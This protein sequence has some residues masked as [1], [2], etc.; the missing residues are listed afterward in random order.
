MKR[1][2]YDALERHG[3]GRARSTRAGW[4]PERDLPDYFAAADV[5]LYP[6]D[7]NLINRTQMPRQTDGSALCGSARGGRVDR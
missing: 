3:A 4:V 2:F 5:A 1:R 6:F 7:D